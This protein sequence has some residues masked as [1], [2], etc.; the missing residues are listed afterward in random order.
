MATQSIDETRWEAWLR[1]QGTAQ[2]EATTDGY[3]SVG[4]DRN[5]TALSTRSTR[6]RIMSSAVSY[7][8]CFALETLITPLG[9]TA[10]SSSFCIARTAPVITAMNSMTMTMMSS[11]VE[12]PMQP[13]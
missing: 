11:C 1:P 10:L 3:I 8:S 13:Q 6:K 12:R 5:G 4:D 7:D 9:S 2:E